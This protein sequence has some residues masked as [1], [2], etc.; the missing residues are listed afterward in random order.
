MIHRKL[1]GLGQEWFPKGAAAEGRNA[2]TLRKR[3]SGLSTFPRGVDGVARMEGDPSTTRGVK[4]DELSTWM[5]RSRVLSF[6]EVSGR[7]APFRF[8]EIR[9]RIRNMSPI[10]LEEAHVH[11]PEW[12]DRL[13]PGEELVITR[14]EALI[15]R[16]V[17]ERPPAK[18]PRRAGTMKGTVLYMAP[19]FNAPLEEF[20]E[21]M[22]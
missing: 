17:A 21:Y 20:A 5:F 10:S 18:E 15:A 11:L 2:R 22:R 7:D 8:A 12:I 19:D 3:G 1:G 14:N 6:G 9:R 4:S 16:L 13:R